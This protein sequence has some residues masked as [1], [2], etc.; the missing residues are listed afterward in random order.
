[1]LNCAVASGG[2]AEHVRLLH[3]T[4]HFFAIASDCCVCSSADP[5]KYL[6][7]LLLQQVVV[8]DYYD[9]TVTNIS[10]TMR[11]Q[12]FN[13]YNN[14]LQMQNCPANAKYNNYLQMQK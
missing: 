8:K 1:M 12:E 11:S 4:C 3:L 5:T 2:I 14:Y 13:K 10:I 6:P 9:V 7:L